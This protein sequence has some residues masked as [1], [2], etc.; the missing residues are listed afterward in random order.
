MEEWTPTHLSP[1]MP[2]GPTS[3]GQGSDQDGGVDTHSSESR[4]APGLTSSGASYRT[5][6]EEWT[7]TCPSPKMPPG[8]T[9]P[10]QGSD[11]DGRVDTHSSDSRHAPG[12]TSSGASYRTR[13]E[14]W[15]PTHPSPKMPPGP[16][17]PGQGSDQDGK[18][19]THSSDSR[20][21]PGLTS[22]GA[23]YRT[24]MEEWTPT[25]P[26]PE[27][28]PGLTSPGQGSDQDG[29]V[30]THSSESRH[31][32]GLTSSGA[33][34]Q[35][36]M[37]EWTPTCPS[38]KMPP[39]P[40]S[41]GQGSDQDGGV[42]THSSES[43]YAPGLTSSGASYRTR[44]EEWTPTC[45]SPEMPPG[46]TSPGQGSDQ[47]GG[48]DTNASESRQ[49]PGPTSSGASYWTK[50]EEWTPTCPSPEMPPGPTS[51]GQGSDQ[52]GRVDTHSSESRHAPGLT[53]SGASY[54]TRM[55]EWTPTCPS[56]E[57]PPGPTSPVQGSD[58]DGGVDTHSSESRHAPGP[59]SSGASRRTRVEVWT[60]PLLSP[61]MPPGPTSPM[62]GSDQD[63]GVD[64][65]SSESRH[66]PGLTSSDASCWTRMEEWTPTCL[67]PEMPP[68]PTSPGQGSDQDGGVDTHSSQSRHAPGPTSSGA[69]C[70]T[71]MEEWTPT[72]LSPDMP[73]VHP[74]VVQAVGPGW[75]SGH[76][77]V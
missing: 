28:P 73:L 44:V 64:T 67:S 20:Y 9:S 39:G 54:Q 1:E 2:P 36:R 30:D 57:M 16:T 34:Y 26:S 12:L 76:P 38:P 45:P 47:D 11:Q 70:Q 50:M 74:V 62:Q 58:Q 27:M 51:P 35:T 21:A 49:A 68:G 33:S 4:Y 60:P 19:D 48:V 41:A 66:A 31:A 52:D 42:D 65:H 56:P 3:A 55:E 6:M 46:P 77:L 13:M 32:P 71:R 37:E 14:E 18:V 40:T 63:G 23:S 53:S 59:T 25:H 69:S 43:R 72:Y 24:R 61:K 75:R 5:R 17:S 15:T 22:S 8:P 29:K 7:P 10:G